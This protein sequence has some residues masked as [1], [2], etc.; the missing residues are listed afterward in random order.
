MHHILDPR[1]GQPALTDVLTATVLTP[2][3]LEAETAAKTTFILGSQAGRQWLN[4]HPEFTGLFILD[5]KTIITN[6]K[7]HALI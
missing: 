2:S 3:V 4:S 6:E 1:T 7:M 5:D